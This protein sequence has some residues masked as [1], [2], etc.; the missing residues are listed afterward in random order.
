MKQNKIEIILIED[1]SLF[2]T[3]LFDFINKTEGMICIASYLSCED[4]LHEIY[5]N[6]LY[7]DIVLLDIG[8][9]GMSGV[10]GIAHLKKIIPNS[11]II[12]LTIQDDDQ[13][14]FNAI[15]SGASGYLLKDSTSEK[16]LE[17]VEEVL[18]GGAPMNS[19]IAAKVL[20]MFKEFVPV[21]GDYN[22]TQREKEILKLL[23]EGLSKKQIAE[24]LFLSFHTIDS[25]IRN[26]YDKLEVH[27][28]SSAVVKAVKEN[29]I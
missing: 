26:I 3:T 11:K 19:S 25:H 7:P 1:N 5:K 12:I 16:I 20:K 23:V 22:L 27:S 18:N 10:E 15:C 21:K 24:K 2:R 28:G 9:P 17:S 13:N 6:M 4:A 14:V 8:L 29:L